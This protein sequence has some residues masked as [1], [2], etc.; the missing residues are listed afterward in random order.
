MGHLVRQGEGGAI[1][2]RMKGGAISAR[3]RVWSN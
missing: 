1:S 3:M 2:A